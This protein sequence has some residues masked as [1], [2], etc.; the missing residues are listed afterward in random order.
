MGMTAFRARER[1]AAVVSALPRSVSTIQP[2][3]AERIERLRE[4]NRALRQQLE[5]LRTRL[6]EFIGEPKTAVAAETPPEVVKPEPT[7]EQHRTP[8]GKRRG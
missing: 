2:T 1:R 3:D 5:E 4:E 6:S 7:R 8:N